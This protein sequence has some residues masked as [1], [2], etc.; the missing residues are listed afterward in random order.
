MLRRQQAAVLSTACALGI[1]N[2]SLAATRLSLLSATSASDHYWLHDRLIAFGLNSH[3]LRSRLVVMQ[4]LQLPPFHDRDE[5]LV[6][7]ST[8]TAMLLLQGGRGK[9]VAI[10]KAAPSG[11]A[12]F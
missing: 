1:R 3:V 8:M 11:A 7:N 5:L 10:K 6:D 12:F 9:K 2:R 4:S